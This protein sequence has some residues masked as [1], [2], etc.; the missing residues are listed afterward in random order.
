MAM[1]RLWSIRPGI[2]VVGEI[3]RAIAL[4]LPQQ[5]PGHRVDRLDEI[6]RIRHVHH[7]VA[8]EGGALLETRPQPAGPDH[9]EVG[10]VVAVDLVERT[11]APAVQRSAPHQPL[12]GTRVEQLRVGDRIDARDLRRR[13]QR[14]GDGDGGVRERRQPGPERRRVGCQHDP[15]RAMEIRIMSRSA[16]LAVPFSRFD[17]ARRSSQSGAPPCNSEPSCPRAYAGRR[18][19][20]W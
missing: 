6:A 5:I 10:D 8:D 15:S 16:P 9:P 12:V 14:S 17:V 19:A 4:V 18:P 1:L 7:A 2:S 11:V 20:R 3:V 13:R